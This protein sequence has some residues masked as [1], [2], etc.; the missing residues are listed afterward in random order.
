MREDLTKGTQ[1]E[2]ESPTESHTSYEPPTESHMSHEPPTESNTRHEPPTESFDVQKC[3]KTIK[4]T[5][6]MQCLTSLPAQTFINV[7]Q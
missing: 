1:R 2:N 3:P 5:K 7:F 4:V 6:L